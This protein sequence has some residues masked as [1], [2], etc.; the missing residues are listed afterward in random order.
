MAKLSSDI[1]Y[2]AIESFLRDGS[3]HHAG[4][5][6][7]STRRALHKPEIREID[8]NV[9]E[10]SIA[11]HHQLPTIDQV[12]NTNL[13]MHI[14]G[15]VANGKLHNNSFGPIFRKEP[16]GLRDLPDMLF[17]ESAEE[18]TNRE[19]VTYN[20]LISNLI[21]RGKII[22]DQLLI[23]LLKD[24][25]NFIKKDDNEETIL[26][27]KNDGLINNY[28]LS[29]YESIYKINEEE[30]IKNMESFRR[31]Y[32]NLWLVG[33]NLDLDYFFS[34]IFG[35]FIDNILK[36]NIK[37]DENHL[38]SRID[39]IIL[40]CF[41][42]GDRSALFKNPDNDYIASFYC[43]PKYEAL[44]IK[45]DLFMGINYPTEDINRA[46]EIADLIMVSLE[47]L[48]FLTSDTNSSAG[49]I[50]G[51]DKLLPPTMVD[52]YEYIWQNMYSGGRSELETYYEDRG[53]KH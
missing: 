34:S 22:E 21:C 11:A 9:S 53:W 39:S 43:R 17:R 12:I 15:V 6:F 24:I 4:S 8:D 2:Q 49:K 33:V 37:G 26:I 29:F 13:L 5:P 52:S 50:A 19:K 28:K 30:L 48:A 27:F 45:I 46:E 16:Q 51:R 35:Q 25:F 38:L 44:P 36:D 47:K 32:P 18:P 10:F 40:H 3:Y 23:E 20:K 31:Y 41:E 14:I 42:K 1:D 7:I